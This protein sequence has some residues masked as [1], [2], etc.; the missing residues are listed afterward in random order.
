MVIF[1]KSARGL[2]KLDS[3]HYFLMWE[4]IEITY[5]NMY[6]DN[7]DDSLILKTVNVYSCM[8]CVSI[9]LD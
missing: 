3:Y 9:K 7:V 1:Y 4:A 8:E 5:S 2:D 6:I